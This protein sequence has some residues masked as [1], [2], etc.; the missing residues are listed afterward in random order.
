MEMLIEKKHSDLLL[1]LLFFLTEKKLLF[2]SDKSIFCTFPFFILKVAKTNPC[3]M[4][5][6]PPQYTY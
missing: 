5:T 1:L 2:P 3:I 4:L 6:V